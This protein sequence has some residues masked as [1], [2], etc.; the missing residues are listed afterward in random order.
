[1]LLGFFLIG[2]AKVNFVLA[3][4][5]YTLSG[6]ADRDAVVAQ[7]MNQFAAL[8]FDSLAGQAG[9]TT[10][11]KPPMPY[12]R[13]VKV[14]SLSPKLERVTIIITPANPLFQPD[15]TV[16]ERSKPSKNPFKV[17]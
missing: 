1:M 15:T 5:F 10:V 7:Q 8:P 13:T 17:Q 9:T 6:G 12:T 4:R 16:L 11:N 3:R 14:D 2:L